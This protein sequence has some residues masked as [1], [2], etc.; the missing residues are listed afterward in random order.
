MRAD[1]D[2]GFSE[3]DTIMGKIGVKVWIYKGELAPGE[4]ADQNIKTKKSVQREGLVEDKPV[5]RRG[6]RKPADAE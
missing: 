6:R 4:M 3:A 1:V 2:Y 5:G